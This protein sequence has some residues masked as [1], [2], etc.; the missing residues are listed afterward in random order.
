MTDQ[1]ID[2]VLASNQASSDSYRQVERQFDQWREQGPW[3]VLFILP[4]ALLAFRRGW[5]FMAVFFLLL[6]YNDAHAFSWKDIWLNK[7]QQAAKAFRDGRHQQA[8]ELFE[9]KPWKGAAAYR[10]GQYD[11]AV[12][13]FAELNDADSHYNR[14]NSLAGSGRLQEAIMAYEEALKLNPGM[15]DA[16][17]NKNLVTEMLRQQQN[18]K[19]QDHTHWSRYRPGTRH[20]R[21]MRRP[22][23]R[24]GI[25]QGHESLEERRPRAGAHPVRKI[26]SPPAGKHQEIRGL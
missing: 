7:N 17:F 13:A 1:D 22:P 2:F 11:N 15:E 8:A 18:E 21:R 14:G 5:I 3:L 20:V 16:E 4:V 12:E 23:G 26:N 6:S 19:K 9:S 25:Q 24:S 10:A